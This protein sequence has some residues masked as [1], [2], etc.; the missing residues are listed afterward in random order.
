M[1]NQNEIVT[2]NNILNSVGNKPQFSSKCI[3]NKA[4]LN[5]QKLEKELES[6]ARRNAH[7]RKESLQD[8]KN[9]VVKNI[10]K[11]SLQFICVLF[12]AWVICACM[13]A[14]EIKSGIEFLLSTIFT[15]F[16]GALLGKYI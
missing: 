13:N 8:I 11:Y 10:Y 2:D 5:S 4:T 1:I 6:E 9:D 16:V 7:K 3:E 14:N 15:L 12:I